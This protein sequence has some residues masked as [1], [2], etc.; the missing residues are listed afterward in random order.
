MLQSN[1]TVLIKYGGNAMVDPDLQKRIIHSI[2]ELHQRDVNVVIVHGGGP[3]IKAELESA[4]VRSE[5]VA[6]QR[7]TTPEAIAHVEKALRG[8]VNAKLIS[9][10]NSEGVKAVGLSG[11]DAAMV[12]GEKRQFQETVDGQ[13]RTVDMGRVA[14]IRSVDTT[15]LEILIQN[16]YIPVIACIATDTEGIDYNVNADMMAGHIAGALSVDQYIVLTD[17]DGL[18]ADIN[19]PGSLFHTLS[20]EE[21]EELRQKGII[22]GGMIPKLESC[23]IAIQGGAG[24]CRILNGTKPNTLLQLLEGEEVG[25]E[26]ISNYDLKS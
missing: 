14:D 6:G 15:L 16:K 24:S 11:K 20:I 1:Q 12:L 7:V 23:E 25:T 17:V 9:I 18:M 8:V 3:F 10:F 13:T 21:L 5:F 19:D 2:S 22:K 4:G 26:I